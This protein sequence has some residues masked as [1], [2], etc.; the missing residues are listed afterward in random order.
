MNTHFARHTIPFKGLELVRFFNVYEKY[1][2]Q[3]PKLH[4]SKKNIKNSIIENYYNFERI[5][6]YLIYFKI[7]FIPVVA[8]VNFHDHYASL[9]CHMIFQ[10]S[11]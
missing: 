9:Q 7:Q 5:A 8:K 11:F 1:I 2:L 6:F 10:K 4:L 3:S